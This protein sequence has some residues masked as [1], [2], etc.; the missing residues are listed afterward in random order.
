MQHDVLKFAFDRSCYVAL[1]AAGSYCVACSTLAA[2]AQQAGYTF[3]ADTEL[4]LV[5]VSVRDKS[6]NLVSDLKPEDF[7]FSKTT[8]RRR[9]F[10]STSKT[11]ETPPLSTEAA[12]QRCSPTPKKARATA[13]IRNLCSR[14]Q[15][16][17]YQGP[18]ADCSVLR[19][20]WHAAGR[21][22]AL[23]TAAQ[24][25]V[26]KQ[27]AAGRSGVRR[28]ARKLVALEP[29]FHLRPRSTEEGIA[30]LQCGRWTRL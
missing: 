11:L 24:N 13:R 19:F 15:N 12:G 26:D 22:R 3:R 25:Y 27:M 18:P 29:G 4:V 16:S 23:A 17:G 5:N 28:V 7:K 20:V 14:P 21:D 1:V 30:V 9:S 6:G 8:S 2:L 10:R